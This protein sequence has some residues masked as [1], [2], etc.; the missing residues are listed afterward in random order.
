MIAI[1]HSERGLDLPASAT[2]DGPPGREAV[3]LRM[4]PVRF[5]GM[6]A[7][8]KRVTALRGVNVPQVAE[9]VNHRWADAVT[10][11]LVPHFARKRMPLPIDTEPSMTRADMALAD[12]F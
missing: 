12:P 2:G 10:D 1:A 3:P 9:R 7:F 8:I 11:V 4:S 5:A 6:P